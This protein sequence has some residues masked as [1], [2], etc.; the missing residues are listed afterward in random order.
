MKI[1][2]I[3][4]VLLECFAISANAEND[5]KTELLTLIKA[6]ADIG[7]FDSRDYDIAELMMRFFYSYQ[8]FK[9]LSPVP[10]KAVSSGTVTMCNSDFVYDALY[11]A[12]RINPPTPK[13]HM[14]TELGYCEDNGFYSF[15]GG[16][17]EYFSTDVREIVKI[18]PQPD[19]SEYVVFSNYYTQ[20]ENPPVF[21]YSS[22]TVQRDDK[23]YYVTAIKMNADFSALQPNFEQSRE[24]GTHPFSEYLPEVVI[25]LTAL[26]ACIVIYVFFTNR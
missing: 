21:E 16:Y 9:I 5:D 26:S 10:P 23:G 3:L 6:C 20:G 25:L 1:T 24:N 12:F 18:I 2:I 17:D 11:R 19:G 14:L 4:I 15:Y 7:S 22:M 8:N 13:P